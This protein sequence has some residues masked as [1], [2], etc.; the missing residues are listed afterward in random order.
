MA[1]FSVLESVVGWVASLGYQASTRVPKDLPDL[2]VT[3]D[4][5]NDDVVSHVG[6]ASVAIRVWAKTDA[7]AESAANALR[8]AMTQGEPPAGIHSARAEGGRFMYYDESTRRATDQF[9]LSVSY[10]LEI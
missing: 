7:E 1:V 5:T 10:Q 8:L 3:V 9:V 2:F 4:R 6:L